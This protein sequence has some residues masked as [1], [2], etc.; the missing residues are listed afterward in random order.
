M[1]L[2]LKGI[3]P[4][5]FINEYEIKNNVVSVGVFTE[6]M[7]ELAIFILEEKCKYQSKAASELYN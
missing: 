3:L 2:V 1:L 5:S 7:L 4:I 6:I